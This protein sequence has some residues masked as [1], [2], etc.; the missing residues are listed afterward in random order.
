MPCERTLSRLNTISACGW[1]NFKSASAKRNRP[2]ANAFPTSWFATSPSCC[3]PPVD[4]M[5]RS[6][7]KSPPPGS[8]SGV[9]GIARIPA[10]FDSFPADSISSWPVVFERWLHGFVTIPPK[11]PVGNVIW[12]MLS[13]SGNDRY[14]SWISDANSFVWSS[15]EF[16]DAWT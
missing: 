16:A 14:T 11:P 5:T 8:G 3:G 6:T 12:K 7:G 2:L 15:V 9:R 4:E 13:V 1:S 10:I